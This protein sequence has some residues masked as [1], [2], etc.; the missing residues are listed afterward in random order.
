MWHSGTIYFSTATI[1]LKCY[2]VSCCVLVFI[3]MLLIVDTGLMLTSA[4]F[5]HVLHFFHITIHIR[6]VCVFLAPFFSSL[7][8]LVTYHLT[9][10]LK[11]MVLSWWHCHHF[12][13]RCIYF[14]WSLEIAASCDSWNF[15]LYNVC[16]IH[17]CTG[18]IIEC[19]VCVKRER[20]K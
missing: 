6:D 5:Y 13:I 12:G 18:Y 19:A 16:L 4:V 3:L 20:I 2:G 11:V 14:C 17:R 8:V 9:K 7:T 10:E 15:H 1:D